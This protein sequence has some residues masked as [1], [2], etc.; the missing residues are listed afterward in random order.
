MAFWDDREGIAM[1]DPIRGC[2][3]IIKTVDGGNNWIK[4]SCDKLPQVED[5]EAA[6]AAS[7][8]N[9]SLFGNHV[10]IVTGGK[11]ARVFHS[12]NR[13][14]TWN[15]Y[16]TPIVQGAKMTGIFSCDF[17]DEKTGI[18]FGG[19]WENQTLNQ[20]NKAV[21]H[22]GGQTWKLIADGKDPSYRSCVQYIG[23]TPNEIIAVGIPG[24]S[25]ST[26]GGLSW[27]NISTESFYTVRRTQ[28]ILWFGGAN[29]MGRLE[30]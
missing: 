15:V 20:N 9:I 26:D 8:S 5:G 11:K 22:D 30:L 6:F 16:H 24:I 21:T 14:D 10:W 4:I 17:F 28:H 1:G 29:K 12:D 7:N 23:N 27:K 18:I 19:D 2:L 25:L 3:S 13:G